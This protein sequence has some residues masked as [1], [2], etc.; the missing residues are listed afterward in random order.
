M[1]SAV[2]REKFVKSGMFV[3]D[4]PPTGGNDQG[5]GCLQFGKTEVGREE[6]P[7]VLCVTVSPG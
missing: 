7:P 6:I 3:I 2:A 4:P 1:D 5:G